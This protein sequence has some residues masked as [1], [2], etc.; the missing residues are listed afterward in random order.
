MLTST[1]GVMVRLGSFCSPPLTTR[2]RTEPNSF[3]ARRDR[4]LGSPY[5]LSLHQNV[6]HPN[7]IIPRRTIT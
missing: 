1:V 6:A 3:V 7:R 5:R 2:P 4:Q